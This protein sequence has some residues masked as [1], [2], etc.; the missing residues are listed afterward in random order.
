MDLY[1]EAITRFVRLLENVDGAG[2]IEPRVGVLATAD[3]RGR[4]AAR[5]MVLMAVD[6][7]GLVFITDK[8]SRKGRHLSVNPYAA[9]CFYWEPMREQ[10]R[11]EGSVELLS[12]E[13]SDRYWK[14]RSRERQLASWASFQ[15]EPLA[16]PAELEERLQDYRQRFDFGPVPRPQRW[17][18]YLLRP[19]RIEF[20]RCG[21]HRLHEVTC[22]EK[23][24]A[25][26]TVT[27]L[28]P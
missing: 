22:Y 14:A 8:S 23:G 27:M 4:P 26:W 10:T 21:W 1:A 12:D 6:A 24:E 2:A 20:W 13:Q 16:D 5:V 28:N 11:I 7:A 17:A 9:L 19:D 18:G 25:G 15:S 3:A